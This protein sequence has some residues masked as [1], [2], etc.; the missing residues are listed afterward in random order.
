MSNTNRI[1]G[2][3]TNPTLS[4][5]SYAINT[6]TDCL[7]DWYYKDLTNPYGY[8]HYSFTPYFT[9]WTT[10]PVVEY[11]DYPVMDHWVLEDGSQ[12]LRWAVSGWQKDE[13]VV[14]LEDDCIVVKGEKADKF[15]EKEKTHKVIHNKIA[16]RNFRVSFKISEKLDVS[17]IVSKLADGILTVT[18]PLSEEVQKRNRVIEI[19]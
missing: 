2:S 19:G 16:K 11:P 4:T 15:N 7:F 12:V 17:K 13:I 18:I 9:T 5:S 14:S 6:I 3:C 8:G 10:I 1:T